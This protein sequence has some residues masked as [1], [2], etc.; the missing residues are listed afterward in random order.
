[1]IEIRKWENSKILER[2]NSYKRLSACAI[3]YIGM[4]GGIAQMFNFDMNKT[5]SKSVYDMDLKVCGKLSRKLI[6]M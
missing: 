2:I 3:P 6:V 5:K 1:M 4:I